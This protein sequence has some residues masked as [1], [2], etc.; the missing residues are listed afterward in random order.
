[1]RAVFLDRDGVL[2]ADRGPLK[3]RSDVE[4]LPGVGPALLALHQARFCL[5]V[6]SNQTVVSRGLL[7]ESQMLGLHHYI[8]EKIRQAGGPSLDGFFYCPH[9]PQ[10][11]DL[12]YRTVCECRKP[13]IG[14]L[15]RA[16]RALDVNLEKSYLVGDR[17]SDILAGKLAGCTTIQLTTGRHLDKPIEVVGGFIPAQAD[18]VCPDLSQAARLILDSSRAGAQPEG[19]SL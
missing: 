4:L 8:E 15:Q 10:A 7:D 9:H 11:T 18:W 16:A 12:R 17:P 1:M 14:L 5:P 6:V 2:V 19:V 13:G 3:H